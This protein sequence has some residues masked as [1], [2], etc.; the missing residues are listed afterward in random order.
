MQ[1]CP[2]IYDVLDYEM[3]ES[4]RRY[5]QWLASRPLCNDCGEHI[6]DD[7]CYDI[8]GVLICIDCMDEHHKVKTKERASNA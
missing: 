3:R 5:E 8:N 4:D 1:K 6:A 2:D 7:V